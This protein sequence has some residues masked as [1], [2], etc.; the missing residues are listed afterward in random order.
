VP[1][2]CETITDAVFVSGA[3]SDVNGLYTIGSGLVNEKIWWEK[4]T[5]GTIIIWS[6]AEWQI[7]NDDNTI[8]YYTDSDGAIWPWLGVWIVSQGEEPIPTVTQATVADALNCCDCQTL[9]ELLALITADDVMAE[10]WAN[11]SEGSQNE[12]IANVC[13]AGCDDVT[14]SVNGVGETFNALEGCPLALNVSFHDQL[15]RDITPTYQGANLYTY[16]VRWGANKLA[17]HTTFINPHFITGHIY[18]FT[19]ITFGYKIGANYFDVNGVATTEAL[20][21]PDGLVIDWYQ[22]ENDAIGC[23]TRVINVPVP[24]SNAATML[25][26]IATQNGL[27]YAGYNDWQLPPAQFMSQ[28]GDLSLSP[29]CGNFDPFNNPN[30]TAA[31]G[32]TWCNELRADLTTNRYWYD[33]GIGLLGAALATQNRGCH[34]FRSFTNAELGI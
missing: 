2:T 17:T 28:I 7:R 5:T 1:V 30:S 24:N 15:G 12:I 3:G 32:S 9:E 22:A 23:L 20:A 4:T 25:T 33:F 26:N 14:L 21:F 11:L 18:R 16:D 6:G 31:L 27:N 34:M 10:V 13:S 8:R 19:G 29:A